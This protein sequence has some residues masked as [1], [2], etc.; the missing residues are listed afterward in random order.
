MKFKVAVLQKKSLDRLCQKSTDIVIENMKEASDNRADILLLPEAFLTG[1]ELPMNNEEA[2]SDDS[3]YIRQICDAA[4]RMHL[5]VVVT[6]ITKGTKKPQNSAYVV[7][8]NGTVLL[9]YSKVHTC[10]FADEACLESGDAFHVCDF[11]GIKI[12]IMICYDREY[13]ES[14]RVLMM[15]GVE[16]ILVPNDCGSMR[17]RLNA[18]STRA[19]ENTTG[20]AMA[21]TNGKNAG[22][23]CAFSPICWDQDGNCVDNVLLIAD[24]LT[25]GLFYAE[26]DMDAIRSYREHEMMGNTYRKVKTYDI[27]MNSQI[28]APFIRVN[29]NKD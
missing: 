17:L 20:I 11:H 12:G 4:K 21:N 15:K 22:N 23:S 10:D 29:Q 16:I 2:L 27:L 28:E 8:K 18:L 14:A 7:N 5:G 25:E 1:Y 26:F 3:F 6:A 24:D 13:P 9:K 19:Y